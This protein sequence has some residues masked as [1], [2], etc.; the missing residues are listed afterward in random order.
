MGI[1]TVEATGLESLTTGQIIKE[2]KEAGLSRSNCGQE[3]TMYLVQEAA[4]RLE[5]L[6][7]AA[8]PTG[9]H[10]PFTH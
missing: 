4:K 8:E 3:Y 2:L 6:Y 9:A 7:Y 5:L 10:W 1:P